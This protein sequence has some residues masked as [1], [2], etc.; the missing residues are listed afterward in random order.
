MD[1]GTTAA[2]KG[3]AMKGAELLDREAGSTSQRLYS[4]AAELVE[5]GKSRREIED[6]LVSSGLDPAA[7]SEVVTEVLDGQWHAEGGDGGLLN[8]VGV[9]H[10]GFGVSLIA[11]GAAATAGSFFASDY[12]EVYVVAY[13]AIA[14]GAID[15]MYGVFR[16]FEGA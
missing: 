16:F 5:I 2:V 11:L 12:T 15:F 8:E 10:M 7:A 14:A 1:A 13:G 3:R 6:E 4:L 9:R